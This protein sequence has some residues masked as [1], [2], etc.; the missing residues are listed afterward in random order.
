MTE[1]T[2]S[3]TIDSMLQGDCTIGRMTVNNNT[4]GAFQC[5]TLELP[6]LNNITNISCIPA[7]TYK[8][9]F[10]NS[11]SNGRVLELQDVEGRT[12]IQIHAGNFTRQILGCILVGESI[13]FLDGD[14][15]PDVTNSRNTLALVLQY[16]GKEG[17]ITINRY[18]ESC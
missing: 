9:K 6:W 13:T 18:G 17:T 16:A 7:G 15:I 5:F 8:Y 11:P 2:N 4:L 1:E 3:I 14:D 12:Y 10:R